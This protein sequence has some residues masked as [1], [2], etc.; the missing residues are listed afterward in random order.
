ML[1]AAQI[2]LS[3]LVASA[4]LL[5]F[6]WLVAVTLKFLWRLLMAPLLPMLGKPLA[7]GRFARPQ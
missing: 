2:T 3:I 1:L 4:W 5:G 7:S 6:F